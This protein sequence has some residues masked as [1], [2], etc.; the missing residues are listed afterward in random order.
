MTV[1]AITPP[2]EI[3]MPP[4]IITTVSEQEMMMSAALLLRMSKRFC[5]RRKPPPQ[6]S[7]ASP[8]MQTKMQIVIVIRSCVSVRRSRRFAGIFVKSLMRYSFPAAA[9]TRP[10]VSL[11]YRRPSS[12]LTTGAPSTT[13][14]M[15]TTA[16]YAL[17]A[18]EDTFMA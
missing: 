8:Y 18:V 13:S 9:A 1:R 15:M 5:A 12:R 17:M 10:P 6:T 14:K 16:L 2:T 3:S 4:P 11:R 7:I